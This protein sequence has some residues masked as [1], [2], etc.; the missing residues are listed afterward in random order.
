MRGFSIAAAVLALAGCSPADSTTW[1]VDYA[2]GRDTAD[3]RT[4]DAGPQG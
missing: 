1:Y 2:N 4:A 3:G